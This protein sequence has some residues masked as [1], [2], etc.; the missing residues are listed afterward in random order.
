M[1]EL[2]VKWQTQYAVA[3][4]VLIIDER[5]KQNFKRLFEMLLRLVMIQPTI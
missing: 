1:I 5:Q 2:Y 4:N 3:R